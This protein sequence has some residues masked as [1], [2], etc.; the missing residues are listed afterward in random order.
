[1]IKLYSFD[2]FDTLITRKTATPKGIFAI[3]NN[4]LKFDEQFKDI[5][6]DIK[7][8]FYNYRIDSE[9]H[10]RKINNTENIQSDITINDIYSYIEYNYHLSAEQTE[11]IKNLE[12]Q[13]EIQNIIPIKENIDEVCEL[14]EKRNRVVLISDMYLPI[15]TIRDILCSINPIFSEIKIYL[16]S[17]CGYMK[18]KCGLYEYVKEHENIKYSEWQHIGDNLNSDYN[19]PLSFGINAKLF[20]YV[21]LKEYEKNI[22]E[23]NANNM[24]I[25]LAIGCAKNIRLFNN[26]NN[27]KFELGV[28][29]AGV[30]FYPYI[31]WLIEQADKRSIDCLYFV[32]RDGY[33][34]KQMAEIL[35]KE[36][37]LNIKT[38][39]LYSSKKALRTAALDVNNKELSKQ[40][41]TSLLWTHTKIDSV[42]G[43]TEKEFCDL[44]PKEFRKY[45]KGLRPSKVLRLKEFLLNSDDFIKLVAE[46]N[47]DKKVMATKYLKQEILKHK[48]ERIA[49][50]DID[51]SG[52][53]QNCMSTIIGSFTDKELTSFYMFSTPASFIPIN[54]KTNYFSALHRPMLGHIIELFARAPHGQTLGYKEENDKIV[55]ILE[56]I[57][58]KI[59]DDWN[60]NEYI[61][62]IKE[63]T[64]NFSQYEKEYNITFDNQVLIPLYVDFVVNDI[65]ADTANLIGNIVH[66]LTGTEKEEF[67]PEISTVQA[68]KYL[69]TDKLKTQSTNCS[70]MRSNSFVQSIIDYKETHPCFR[71]EIINIL[72]SKKKNIA[73]ITILGFKFDLSGIFWKNEIVYNK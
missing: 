47:N 41:I 23:K 13:T 37:N 55:P 2:I 63:F 38:E 68:I 4:K 66:N 15:N 30:L 43:I 11:R 29:L 26:E 48:D 67:A 60:F 7:E 5:P 14:I 6:N 19:K 1:M 17:E 46:R 32:A 9:F 61:N 27:A 40:F 28:S 39:Y 35:I 52:Y 49:F 56:D 58:I 45:K 53:T 25:Q 36:R 20:P 42:C 21:K 44:I 70:K 73:E 12:I 51:G 71:K 18:Q 72:I 69:F 22:L 59:F 10:L 54:I 24:F 50:V 16:S 8:N 62:G 65:D 64:Y 34:F 57:D 3:V 31:S 33:L